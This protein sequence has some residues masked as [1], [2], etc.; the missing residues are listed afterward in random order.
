MPNTEIP[1][2]AI[3]TGEFA[4]HPVSGPLANYFSAIWVHRVGNVGTSPVVIVPD[5]TVDL[6]WIGGRLRLAG[7]DRNPMTEILAPDTTVIGF[8]FRPGMAA[9][10]LGVSLDEVVDQRVTLDDL[11]GS[12][13]GLL[14]HP[15]Q[16]EPNIAAA[17]ATL[18]RVLANV[19]PAPSLRAGRMSS[20]FDLVAAGPPHGSDLV[21]WLTATLGMS[22]RTLRRRF[23]QSY[24]YGPKTLQRIIRFGRYLGLARTGPDATAQL[25]AEAGYADQAHLIR[26]A[27]RLTGAT[28]GQLEQQFSNRS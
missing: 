10:W 11:W 26:E 12:R 6:Q 21:A 20:A 8:R 15:V 22:E 19:D 9:E 16:D 23:D 13:S 18:Q 17:I 24:G 7:P 4:A 1:P 2:L 5:A 3:A 25:A 27:R 28:P 14:E